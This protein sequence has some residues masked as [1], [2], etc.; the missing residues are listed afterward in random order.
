MNS[1]S[2]VPHLLETHQKI[3][4]HRNETIQEFGYDPFTSFRFIEWVV[5]EYCSLEQT[6]HHDDG[7]DAFDPDTGGLVEIKA[8]TKPSPRH[9]RKAYCYGNTNRELDGDKEISCY[10]LVA[11]DFRS[12]T[13][14][15]MRFFV[16]PPSETPEGGYIA[17]RL[18]LEKYTWSEYEIGLL[19]L[20]EKV[21]QVIKN[22]AE[23]EDVENG[24]G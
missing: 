23:D 8:S 7:F 14:R 24:E 5:C 21:T 2:S 17:I 18:P 12:E 19:G 9:R 13:D 20:P 16:V 4:M 6:P 11:I 1:A 15:L 3:L 22:A 10:I